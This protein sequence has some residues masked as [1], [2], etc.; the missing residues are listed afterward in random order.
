MKYAGT[1]TILDENGNAVYERG[2]TGD[3]MIEAL[4]TTDA[5]VTNEDLERAIKN[6][7]EVDEAPQRKKGQ[8][9]CCGRKGYKHAEGCKYA[10]IRVSPS[11]GFADKKGTKGRVN[12]F[13]PK[14][15]CG[16]MGWRHK[17]DCPVAGKRPAA[18]STGFGMDEVLRDT[19]SIDYAITK[20]D[21]D[22]IKDAQHNEMTSV[23]A[24]AELGLDTIAV[25]RAFKCKSWSDYRFETRRHAG[26]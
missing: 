14:P 26:L 20:Q 21:F 22:D 23:Q 9:S 18:V 15:C 1:I 17:K 24:A 4:L 6:I 12:K 3:E 11:G 19:E 25:I 8:W 13:E 10:G 7:E 16:S 2:L 5:A